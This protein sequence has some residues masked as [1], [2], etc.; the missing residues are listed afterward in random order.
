MAV[1]SVLALEGDAG[2]LA[3]KLQAIDAVVRRKAPQYGGI[4]STVVRTENGIKIFNLWQA[5][6]GRHEMADDPEVQA[7]LRDAGL[8]EPAAKGYEV[9]SHRSA[10]ELG[11]EISRRMVE[12]VW[13][14]GNLGALDELVAEDFVGEN[15]TTGEIHGRDALRE[16]VRMYRN[17]FG[18]MT[19]RLDKVIAEGDW[20]A[21]HWTATGTHTGDVMGI[22]PGGREVTV[23]GVQFD[24]IG[25]DGKIVASKGM[26][27]ALG[28]LQ[29]I[30]VVQPLGAAATA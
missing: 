13:T 20:V 2:E 22:P 11:K 6:A 8:P 15:P 27:D 18:D 19:M 3:T 7:A 10:G 4:S 30:G 24:R 23:S 16:V 25:A 28:M 12:E 14:K 17:G 21:T 1:L 26:F 29:Q 9:L 5:E